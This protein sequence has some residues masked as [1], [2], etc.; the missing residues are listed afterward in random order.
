MGAAVWSSVFPRGLGG[1]GVVPA[2]APPGGC[3]IF[4]AGLVRSI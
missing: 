1:K 4:K 3:G 2:I